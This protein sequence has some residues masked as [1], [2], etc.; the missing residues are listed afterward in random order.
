[1]TAAV[2]VD[3]NVFVYSRDSRDKSKQA[4]AAAWLDQLWSERVGRTSMQVVSEYYWTVT[5]KLAAPYKAQEAWDHVIALLAWSPQPIDDA[6]IRRGREV[7]ARH[8]LSWW[9]SLIIAAAEL[10]GCPLLLSEDLQDGGVY[11]SV[12]VRNPFT[13][14]MNESLATYSPGLPAAHKHPA[15]G[16]PKKDPV[17]GRGGGLV[18]VVRNSP[19]HGLDPP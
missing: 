8:K 11:G 3:T 14:S 4:R 9:D 17:K 1:M 16:R 12:T 6:L 10:Q 15:R 2:F 13:M 5:R 7:E 18:E 19:L